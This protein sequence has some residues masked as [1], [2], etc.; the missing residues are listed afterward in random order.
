MVR[1]LLTFGLLGICGFWLLFA[2]VPGLQAW[3]PTIALGD[4][5]AFGGNGRWMAV[6]A[7]L[8]LLAFIII[9]LWLV[10]TTVRTVRAYHAK[11]ARPGFR[12]PLSIEIFW[13]ALPIAMTVA[14][15][16]AS[17]PLWINL[18]RP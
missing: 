2:Y 5:G 18:I 14:L 7:L 17:Y 1:R 6:L 9:Q 11:G 13:T 16:W 15:A 8:S 12:L 3:L 4:D 10:H